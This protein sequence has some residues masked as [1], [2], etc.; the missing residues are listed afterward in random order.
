MEPSIA[1]YSIGTW[2]LLPTS[3]RSGALASSDATHGTVSA[4][5]RRYL[6]AIKFDGNSCDLSSAPTSYVVEKLA[7]SVPT[8]YRA[9]HTL[10]KKSAAKQ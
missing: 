1:S 6:L 3:L 10:Y 2:N 4:L 7:V 8:A 5:L 9:Q